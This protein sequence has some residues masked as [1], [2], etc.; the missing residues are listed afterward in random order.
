M[1][2]SPTAHTFTI[3]TWNM[4]FR[5][6]SVLD[7]LTNLHRAPDLL[8][9]QEI[10]VEQA[11]SFRKRLSEMGLENVIYSGRADS[12]DKRYGN[13]I[14]SRWPIE[15]VDWGSLKASLPW[16]QLVAHGVIKVG[17]CLVNVITAHVLNDAGN[18]W[19]KID[20]FRVLAKIV[21]G[22]K[23]SHSILT[24]DFNEPQFALQGDRIVTFGQEQIANDTYRCWNQWQFDGRSGTGEEWDAAVR[25][26]FEKR[27]DHG[28]RHAFWDV[29]GQ[30]KME[31]T[32]VSRGNPR[33]FDHIFISEGFRVDSCNYPHDVRLKG[34][35]D[36]SALIAQIAYRSQ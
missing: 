14:A 31:P 12:S 8:T 11:D 34:L 10:S 16:P 1:H 19:A 20:T 35:S 4:N 6:A 2:K 27:D 24:G 25:W 26:F 32:H 33:R 22:V 13:I 9:L 29:S 5:R 30:R 28:L 21:G 15:S 3:M 7:P 17:G 36:H 23:G 18:G